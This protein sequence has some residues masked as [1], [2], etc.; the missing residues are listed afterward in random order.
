MQYTCATVVANDN[1]NK[2]LQLILYEIYEVAGNHLQIL[3]NEILTGSSSSS[4]DETE[5]HYLS[6][7]VNLRIAI[8][9]F[10]KSKGLTFSPLNLGQI[11]TSTK[12]SALHILFQTVC[13]NW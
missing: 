8:Y 5:Q 12:G 3:R 1:H 7:L 13:N 4:L 2:K 9:D 6:S 11:P 10:I